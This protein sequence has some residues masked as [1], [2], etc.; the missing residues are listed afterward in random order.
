MFPVLSWCVGSRVGAQSDLNAARSLQLQM[1]RRAQNLWPR[2]H[3]SI[4]DYKRSTGRWCEAV[5]SVA[6]FH[7]VTRLGWAQDVPTSSWHRQCLAGAQ[8][9]E[10][11]C[12]DCSG[13]NLSRAAVAWAEV[14]AA[15]DAE[16]ETGE[17]SEAPSSVDGASLGSH[18]RWATVDQDR[19]EWPSLE[20]SLVQR[21]LRAAIVGA[22]V[23][24]GRF[25]VGPTPQRT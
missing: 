1:C 12:A 8:P 24:A 14:S 17:P 25:M 10:R 22:P 7:V 5:M 19:E 23:P 16:D 20:A 4:A 9:I 6:R 2:Q 21:A 13:G 3:E 11:P 15:K 18:R